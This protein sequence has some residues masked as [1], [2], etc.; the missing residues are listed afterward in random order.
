MRIRVRVLRLL[1]VLTVVVLG[2]AQANAFAARHSSV[3]HESVNLPTQAGTWRDLGPQLLDT[4]KTDPEP[5]AT[6]R[7]LS[8]AYGGGILFA[9]T[10]GGGVW[11][12]P[13]SGR[14]WTPRTDSQLSSLIIGSMAVDPTNPKIV[15]AGTGD[16]G[17]LDQSGDGIYRS[18]DAGQTWTRVT[19][20]SFSQTAIS[21]IVVD[22][23]NG[24]R[25]YAAVMN[26]NPSADNLGV[27]ASTN[28]GLS[29]STTNLRDAKGHFPN[30]TDL[31]IDG[32]GGVYAAVGGLGSADLVGAGAGVANG[33]W[34]SGDGGQS[35]TQV[36]GGLPS[37]S[38]ACQ[39]DFSRCG[40]YYKLALA[41]DTA[42]NSPGQQT[43]YAGVSNTN[44]SDSLLGMFRTTDGGADWTDITSNLESTNPCDYLDGTTGQ[45]SGNL[46][47][48]PGDGGSLYLGRVDIF[49]TDDA[50]ADKPSWR[51]VSH[52]Y[53]TD[54][55]NHC[56]GVTSGATHADQHA[57]LVVPGAGTGGATRL[58]FAND[59]GIY[60]SDNGGQTYSSANGQAPNALAV[61]QFYN[62]AISPNGSRI[63]AGTQDNGTLLGTLNSADGTYRWKEVVGGDGGD[64][65]MDPTNTN[66]MYAENPNAELDKA[67]DGGASQDSWNPACPVPQTPGDCRDQ[68]ERASFI[69]PL[70]MDP[71]DPKTLYLGMTHLWR[72]TDA[73][74]H[75]ANIG[76]GNGGSPLTAV[77]VSPANPNVVYVGNADGNTWMTSNAK[78]SSPGQVSWTSTN[79]GDN[80][81]SA[82]PNCPQQSITAIAVDPSDPSGKTVYVTVDG[83]GTGQHVFRSA[84]GGKSWSDI[85]ASLPPIPF[86]AVAVG[87]T[88]AIFAGANQGVYTS[89]D[90]GRNWSSPGTGLPN[91][92]VMDLVLNGS[93]VNAFTYGRGLWALGATTP[94][95]AKVSLKI[96]GAYVAHIKG[97]TDYETK[98][99]KVAEKADYVVQ[100]QLTNAQGITPSATLKLTYKGKVV[101]TYAM[102]SVQF[103]DGTVGFAKTKAITGKSR[104]GKWSAQFTVIA[105]SVNASATVNFTL[106]K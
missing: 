61:S 87:L 99:I 34:Y 84:D 62:G 85:S 9:G 81:Q 78:A 5:F 56:P 1:P 16:E 59:G 93:T 25:V 95:P 12:S 19:G 28:G 86:R 45:A 18:A 37:Q 41:P 17:Q 66:V 102:G 7:V 6:G 80:C 63:L 51:N 40:G 64:S 54:D 50:S 90:G 29:W 58:Y 13:D 35:W 4:N 26:E 23:T 71:K 60:Y 68:T 22:P 20:V 73:A 11:T 74:A 92:W 24:Q 77:A 104:L 76:P 27:V 103:D 43:L 55:S 48:Q 38:S 57:M 72:T 30:V 14:T 49:K 67:T 32:S 94:P 47:L 65:A 8:L 21:K 101:G 69:A 10:S 75:W 39:G 36:S 88:G 97:N 2:T 3:P 105:G 33:I 89:S 52:V 106:K 53:G 100:Y 82:A 42:G 79:S 46:V 83:F 15:F 98:S 70:V 96:T 91:A 44:Q 31:A